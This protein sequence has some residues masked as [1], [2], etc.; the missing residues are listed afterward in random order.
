[1]F[2]AVYIKGNEPVVESSLFTIDTL[3][4]TGLIQLNPVPF[5]PDNDG[6]EDEINIKIYVDDAIGIKNLYMLL[7]I[8]L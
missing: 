3:P 6:V 8:I 1:V 2:S 7:W 4:P 5:S